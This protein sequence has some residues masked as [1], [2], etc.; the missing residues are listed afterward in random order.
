MKTIVF[1]ETNFSGLDTFKYCSERGYKSVLITDSFDRFKHWFPE[2]C[3]YKLEHADQV[4]EVSNSDDIDELTKAIETEVGQ[5]DAV[6]TFAEIRTKVTATLAQKLG[7]AGSNIEAINIAQDKYRF[8]KV[9]EEKGVETVSC[10]KVSAINELVNIKDTLSYP[11][12]LKPVQGHSSLGATVCNSQDDVNA[13][14]DK[15]SQ[16]DEEWISSEFVV[17]DFL[18]GDLVSVEILTTSKGNHQ[19]VGVSDRDVIKDSVETGASFPLNSDI[20][21]IVEKKACDALDAIG[22]DFG[23]SHVELILT[24][25]GPRLVEVNSRV[26]GSGHS[27]M[28]DLATSR[29]IVGDCVELCLGNIK[30]EGR[31]YPHVRGAAWKCFVSDSAGTINKMP[32]V[33]EIKRLKGVEE[34]W[35]HHGVGEKVESLDSNFSWILQ[36]MCTGESQFDAKSNAASAVN[37]VADNTVIQ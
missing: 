20:R 19:V 3:L 18:Q 23:P 14:V 29:S 10:I 33:D 30:E 8:R 24:E 2:S 37:F 31:L 5:V 21:E 11:C 22:Y 9:I 6:L 4:V 28:M 36:V 7:L 17:E 16:I 12:F 15:F 26:G 32:S 25:Q 34:V 1:I 27:V 35:L 13:I